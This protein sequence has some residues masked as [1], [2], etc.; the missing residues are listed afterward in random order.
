MIACIKKKIEKEGLGTENKPLDL[1]DINTS[2][3]TDMSNLFDALNGRLKKLSYEGYFNISNWNVS[4][5]ENMN[6][7]FGKS[8]F[9]K[10]ISNWNVSSVNN[11]NNMFFLSPLQNNPPKWYKS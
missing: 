9:N 4:K 10:D 8:A 2:K 11:M 6:W 1:N 3:I 5:V 7:M